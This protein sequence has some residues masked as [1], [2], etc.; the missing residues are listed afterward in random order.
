MTFETGCQRPFADGG[1]Y[2]FAV[3]LWLIMSHCLLYILFWLFPSYLSQAV[4]LQCLTSPGGP[5]LCVP[6]YSHP[7]SP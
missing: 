7:V 1:S 6:P 5:C 2:C 4:S 3:E